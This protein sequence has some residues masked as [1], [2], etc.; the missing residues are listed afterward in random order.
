MVRVVSLDRH[1]VLIDNDGVTVMVAQRHDKVFV[2]NIDYGQTSYVFAGES[3]KEA[4]Q[5]F[6]HLI[7]KLVR[8]SYDSKY[9]A[10]PKP[11]DHNNNGRLGNMSPED[12][13]TFV[14]NAIKDYS[15]MELKANFK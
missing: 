13:D 3:K 12:W 7:G 6:L 1:H 11:K 9:F 14:T 15:V 10:S 4:Y 2:R 8:K 5:K